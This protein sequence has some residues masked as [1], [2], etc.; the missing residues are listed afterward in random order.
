MNLPKPVIHPLDT[1]V[2]MYRHESWIA[3]SIAGS[4]EVLEPCNTGL[5]TRHC[6]C[7]QLDAVLAKRFKIANPSCGSIC[8]R[9]LAPSVCVAQIGLVEGHYI[10]HLLASIDPCNSVGRYRVIEVA[11]KHGYEL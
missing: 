11:E 10:R 9:D 8:W 1:T 7:A 6:R 4:K 3:A 5:L 2:V